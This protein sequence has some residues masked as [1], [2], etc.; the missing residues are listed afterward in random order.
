V[1]NRAF[2]TAV[3]CFSI[4]AQKRVPLLFRLV[5]AQRGQLSNEVVFRLDVD[6]EIPR[7]TPERRRVLRERWQ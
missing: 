7:M 5:E 4:S 1:S 6:E 3:R 2:S